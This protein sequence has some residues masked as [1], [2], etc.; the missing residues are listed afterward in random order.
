[1]TLAFYKEK[2]FEVIQTV[3]ELYHSEPTKQYDILQKMIKAKFD[4]AK[5][6]HGPSFETLLTRYY[7]SYKEYEDYSKSFDRET[8]EELDEIMLTNLFVQK[9]KAE[10]DLFECIN[11]M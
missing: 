9:E 4:Y 6:Y 2:Y 1:M 10:K 3:N 11:T 7:T 8:Y 5:Q